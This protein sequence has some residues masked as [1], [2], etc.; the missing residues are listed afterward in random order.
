MPKRILHR[1]KRKKIKMSEKLEQL[2]KHKDPEVRRQALKDLQRQEKDPLVNVPI[3]IRSLEDESWRVRKTAV[4]ILL[5]IGGET[6]IR[7]L[8]HTLYKGNAN[9]RNSAIEALI[10]LGH[11]A[12]DYL[13]NEF[14]DANID[15]KKF[16]ID[17]IGSTRDL[18]AFPL[19]LKTLED[20]DKNI[21]AA[22]V[23]HLSNIKKNSAVVDALI[24]LLK[25][26]DT[27]VAYHVIN[28]LGKI[29]D[30]RAV[31]AL[32]S[33][34]SR[35][36]LRKSAITALGQIADIS[37]ISVIVPFLKNESETVR[38]E[39]LKAVA[40]FFQKGT[41]E[42]IIVENLKN[43]FGDEARNILLPHLQSGKREVS[44]AAALILGL[45][46]DKSAITPLVE[47]SASEEINEPFIRALVFIGKLMPEALIPYFKADDPYQRRLVCKIAG[48]IGNEIFFDPLAESLK[49]R[50]GHVRGNAAVALSSL[51]NP[52]A[53]EYIKSVILDGYEYENIQEEAITA[54]SRLKKWLN[55]DEII[56]WLSDKSSAVRR[57]AALLLGLLRDN[58]SVDALGAALKDSDTRVAK[59]AVDAL[60]AISNSNALNF[61]FTA[62]KHESPEIRRISVIAI[63]K[64]HAKEAEEALIP[65]LIDTNEWVRAAAVEAVGKTGSEKAAEALTQLLSDESGLVRIAVI[66]AL[67]NFKEEKVKKI[68]LPLLNDRDPEIRSAS[69]E[70]LAAFEGIVQDIV[71]LLKDNEWSVRKKV[72][73]VLGK[74]FRDEG[75]AYLRETADMDE[76]SMVREAAEEYLNAQV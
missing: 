52:K 9:A 21:K 11:I 30:A 26:A 32:I 62:L 70:S 43:A 25:S 17:I 24:A 15:V 69:V 27:W 6:V 28:A 20:E 51:N 45:L 38:E 67:G 57:N 41:S 49:D 65:L 53:V 56:S 1:Q 16:I 23:E 54:L 4:E 46:G 39:A 40:Q 3:L 37:S 33:A 42:G 10:E 19:L 2:L 72:V 63:G 5:D 18:K 12:T 8:L 13:I 66:E 74:F 34:L 71:P 55:L 68:L 50:D 59:A 73:D 60:G 58:N 44:A 35:K 48:R 7:E 29:G 36:D 75:F 22:V 31:N 61:L 76:D 64:M 14:K 47:M